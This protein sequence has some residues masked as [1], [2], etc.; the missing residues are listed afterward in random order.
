M[1]EQ[2]RTFL[3]GAFNGK[4]SS[5]WNIKIYIDGNKLEVIDLEL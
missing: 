4:I 2:Q 1:S 3:K 5:K